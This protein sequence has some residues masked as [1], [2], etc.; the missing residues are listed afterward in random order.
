VSRKLVNAMERERERQRQRQRGLGDF[1]GQRKQ[2]NH[3]LAQFEKLQ[4]E[5][6]EGKMALN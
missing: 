5:L 6:N 1:S 3:S 2:G 4:K